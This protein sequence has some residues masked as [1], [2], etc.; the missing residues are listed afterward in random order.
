MKLVNKSAICLL[1]CLLWFC[2][3]A[4]FLPGMEGGLYYSVDSIALKAISVTIPREKFLRETFW[5][6]L[7]RVLD[8]HFNGSI[9]L[10]MAP[11][12]DIGDLWC[13]ISCWSL[14]PG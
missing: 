10:P 2:E 1:V 9:V 7:M 14:L 5:V 8:I 4:V 12:M 13:Y 3:A 6:K 11:T